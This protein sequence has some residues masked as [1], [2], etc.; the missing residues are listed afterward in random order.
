M[1]GVL[2]AFTRLSKICLQQEKKEFLVQMLHRYSVLVGDVTK[3][4]LYARFVR[5]LLLYGKDLSDLF[6]HIQQTLDL[7]LEALGSNALHSKELQK[8]LSDLKVLHDQ[9]FDHAQK[10]LH[11]TN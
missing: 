5:S 10:Y 2:D 4:L 7:F 9:G 1:H 3:A 6:C 8:F 11:K